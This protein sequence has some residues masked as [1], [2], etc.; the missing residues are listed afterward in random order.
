MTRDRYLRSLRQTLDPHALDPLDIRLLESRLCEAL[1]FPWSAEDGTIDAEID[2]P[3]GPPR[4]SPRGGPHG[5]R[6]RSC[7]VTHAAI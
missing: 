7:S 2:S 6:L 4:P 5:V 3:Q 1:M